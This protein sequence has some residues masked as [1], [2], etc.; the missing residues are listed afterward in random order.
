MLQVEVDLCKVH[1]ILGCKHLKLSSDK[2]GQL[3][4]ELSGDHPCDYHNLSSNGVW[5]R[6]KIGMLLMAA[7][8][9]PEAEDAAAK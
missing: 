4:A 3:E 2:D 1:A 8:A 9:A 7:A 6:D 5:H